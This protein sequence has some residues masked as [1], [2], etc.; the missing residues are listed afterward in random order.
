MSTLIPVIK[1]SDIP[2]NEAKPIKAT[3]VVGEAVK[4]KEVSNGYIQVAVPI[5]YTTEA[6]ND[7]TFT[8]RWNVRA[9]WFTPEFKAKYDETK[10]NQ[11]NGFSGPLSDAEVMQYE[12]NMKGL[13][14][15]LFA[16]AGIEGTDFQ[17]LPGTAVGFKTRPRKSD[18][19]QLDISYFFP[20]KK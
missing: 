15:G 8:A 9:E 5:N 14:R 7:A 17:Q 11:K 18:P 6:G 4:L 1:V 20:P 3:G 16:A 12:I 10:S 2:V 13:T 19:S